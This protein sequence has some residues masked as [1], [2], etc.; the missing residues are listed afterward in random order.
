[1]SAAIATDLR[2]L[3][4]QLLMTGVPGGNAASSRVGN[5]GESTTKCPAS[6]RV[7]TSLPKACA[8]RSG[9]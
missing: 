9:S 4:G 3:A 2:L 1:M 7:R 5:A 8:S 6:S